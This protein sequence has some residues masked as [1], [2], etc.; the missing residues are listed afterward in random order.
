MRLSGDFETC[1]Q[2]DLPRI[3][4]WKYAREPSTRILCF[5]WA[6]E[7]GEPDLW[8]PP[9]PPPR[10]LL[11]IIEAGCEFHAW[12]AQFEFNIW[13]AV[14]RLYGL[15]PLP[16]ERFHCT[17]ARALYWGVPPKLEQAAQVVGTSVRKDKKGADLM[18]KMSQPRLLKDS[19]EIRWWDRDESDLLLDL[20]EYC[21]QDVRTERAV[22]RCLKPMPTVERQLWL[23]DQRMNM[24]GLRVDENAVWRMRE[25]VDDELKRLGGVLRGL[26]GGAVDSVTKTKG[27]LKW[28]QNHGVK[29]KSLNKAELPAVLKDPLEPLH[30]MILEIYQEGAKTSTSKLKAMQEYMH[31]DGRVRGLVQYGGALRTLRWAGRGVQ[32]QNYPR[33]S[34]TINA[35]QAIVDILAGANAEWIELTHGQPMEVVSHCLRGCYVPDAGHAFAVADFSA[36]EARVVAWLAGQDNVLNVFRAGADIYALTARAIGSDNRTLGKVLVLACGFGMG[37][38]RFRSTAATYGIDL[39]EEQ[40]KDNVYAWR[41]LNRA[42]RSLWYT[43]DDVVRTIISERVTDRYLSA[44]THLAFR[45]GKDG[46]R[47]HNCLIMRLPSNRP[48]IYRNASIDTLLDEDG[49]DLEDVIRYDGLDF[50]KKWSR[51]RTWGGKLVEN[52]TQ[53]TARDLLADAMLKLDDGSDDLAVTIHDELIAEPPLDRAQDR[54]TQMLTA[55]GAA[56]DWA[57]DL[58]LKAE[59]AVM[60]RYGKE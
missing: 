28:L 34:K 39:T 54:L 11:K 16:I 59:G 43:V 7:D 37:P 53:A 52:A 50:T 3:G 14:G 49:F 1:S 19:P 44:G 38:K 18:R 35:K 10:R 31:K 25:V 13:N 12:N 9:N 55:M 51:I 21:R 57:R 47:L 4:A 56:P 46:S 27:L 26:T 32:I 15:P 2:G 60:M 5:S 20:G 40:A 36:I 24:R 8:F 45:M 22:A 33:P 6:V 41:E 23:L 58:P 29:I 30:R 48:I 17:M 42:T